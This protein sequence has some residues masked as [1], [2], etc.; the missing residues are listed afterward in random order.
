[1]YC[2]KCGTK[3]DKGNFCP[4][5]GAPIQKRQ[6]PDIS[7]SLPKGIS[8]D[9][10][11]VISWIWQERDYTLYY[12][13]DANKVGMNSVP[14]KKEDTLGSAFK[15]MLKSGLELVASEIVMNSD[16]YNGQDL[17]WD[18]L[19]NGVGSTY[20]TFSYIKKIKRN[21]KKSEIM[22]KESI[23]GLTLRLSV[24]QY[25]FVLDYVLKQTPQAKV[26]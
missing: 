23:S 17:P 25:Q 21:P 6:T 18:S 16:A 4:E 8:V 2:S 12:Y 26:K 11:G 15:D 13:M 19:G 14:N 9:G 22:L 10:N 5:C 20:L 24:Q 3:L 1:M 7:S